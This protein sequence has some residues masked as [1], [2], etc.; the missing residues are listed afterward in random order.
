MSNRKMVGLD[1]VQLFAVYKAT[2]D[3]IQSN[4]TK[5]TTLNIYGATVSTYMQRKL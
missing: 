1:T 5:T 2:W 4:T 3:H